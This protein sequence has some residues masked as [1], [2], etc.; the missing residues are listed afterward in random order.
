MVESLTQPLVGIV[1]EAV[2]VAALYA[3]VSKAGVGAISVFLGTVR[4]TNAGKPVSGI[5]YEAYRP[6]AE[7]E[8]NRIVREVEA[9]LPGTRIAAV[10]RLGTLGIGDISV[11]IAA[12]H[13]RR[14]QAMEAA[15]RVIELIKARV[16]VWKL[17]HYVDGT[18]EWVDPSGAPR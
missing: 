14:K 3:G 17:E 7:A 10:H 13:A 8:L 4:D 12:A 9:A 6:M 11:A 18:R 15:Q 1:D 5:D 2:D 16:P